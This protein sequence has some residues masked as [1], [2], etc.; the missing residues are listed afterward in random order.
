M[1]LNWIGDEYFATPRIWEKVFR[2]HGIDSRPVTDR[3]GCALET[4]VQLV[5][6]EEVDLD[7]SGLAIAQEC[8]L[9]G[10]AKFQQIVR[11]YIPRLRR[12]PGTHGFKS[13][14]VFGYN[15]QAYR[16]VIVSQSVRRAIQENK[17]RGVTFVPVDQ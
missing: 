15:F 17:V 11:G 12:A 4:V 8:A 2:P 7:P 10:Q 13:K 14:E 1:Q 6:A 16:Q 5:F 3:K 9:C